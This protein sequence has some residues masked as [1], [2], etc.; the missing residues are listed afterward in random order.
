VLSVVNQ[1]AESS[2]RRKN[3]A[4]LIVRISEIYRLVNILE[5]VALL[6]FSIRVFGSVYALGSQIPKSRPDPALSFSFLAGC[7][8]KRI[9]V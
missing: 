5:K 6:K 9:P 2:R 1:K 7:G 4:P 3:L 8:K